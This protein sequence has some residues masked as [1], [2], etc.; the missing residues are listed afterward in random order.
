MKPFLFIFL[1][2]G[3]FLPRFR[4]NIRLPCRGGKFCFYSFDNRFLVLILNKSSY[5]TS[6]YFTHPGA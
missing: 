2:S 6:M 1:Q 3:L 4:R 5:E